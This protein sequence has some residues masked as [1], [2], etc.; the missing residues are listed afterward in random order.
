MHQRADGNLEPGFI[1][2]DQD[3][4][5]QYEVATNKNQAP[6][7]PDESKTVLT[8]KEAPAQTGPAE[9]ARA[10]NTPATGSAEA[11]VEV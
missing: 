8:L 11:A 4:Q 7:K 5:R 10:R 6:A 3:S 9:E 1:A 2:Y